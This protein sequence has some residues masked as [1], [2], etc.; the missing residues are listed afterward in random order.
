MRIVFAGDWHAD[1]DAAWAAVRVAAE[2]GAQWIVHVGDFFY[3]GEYAHRFLNSLNK[4]L[5]R[6]DVR[7]VFVRGNHD[8]TNALRRAEAIS[9]RDGTATPEGFIPMRQRVFWAPDGLLWTWEGTR[10]VALGGAESIDR[11]WR[12]PNKTWWAD[13]GVQEEAV[14]K[15]IS[16]GSADVV[17]MH[18]VPSRIVV[19]SLVNMGPAMDENGVIGARSRFLLQQAVDAL[20]PSWIFSG[21]HHAFQRDILTYEDGTTGQ[22]IILDRGD[23]EGKQNTAQVLGNSLFLAEAKDGELVHSF[24]G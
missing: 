12:K 19:R 8:D 20:K 7:L 13:E 5:H 21:H 17:V 18:D 2:A 14:A 24:F 22:S 9:E 1:I 15:A 3:T 11:E 4:A 6:Y 10:F 16:Y 23:Y